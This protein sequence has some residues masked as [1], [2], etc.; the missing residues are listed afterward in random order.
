[1]NESLERIKIFTTTSYPLPLLRIMTPP[2][3]SSSGIRLASG[4]EGQSSWRERRMLRKATLK[5]QSLILMS[6]SKLEWGGW[7]EEC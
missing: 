3:L 2:L 6:R 5:L 1:M 4:L 7:V